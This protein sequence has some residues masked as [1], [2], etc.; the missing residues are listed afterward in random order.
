MIPPHN[1]PMTGLP[2]PKV[3][4]KAREIMTFDGFISIQ[5]CGILI[6]E[7][8][9]CTWQPSVVRSR[10][11]S[12]YSTTRSSF[13]VYEDSF[14]PT[15]KA[16]LQSIERNIAVALHT[17]TDKFERWQAVNYERGE[18]FNFHI[19]A[20]SGLARDPSG[21]R[22]RSIVLYLSSPEAGGETNFRALNVVIKPEPGR[23][24]VW[25]NLLPD[26]SPDYA[27]IHAGMPVLK[28][29]KTILVT[30]EREK[31]HRSK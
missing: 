30:W 1:P 7:L 4:S 10:R 28:G 13:A 16:R 29:S 9:T 2:N 5:E 11:Q 18:H 27:M 23:L 20:G 21:E 19:D 15:L 26:G 24:I 22:V 25:N 14:T 31:K 17:H 8:A 12:V 6:G 3:M